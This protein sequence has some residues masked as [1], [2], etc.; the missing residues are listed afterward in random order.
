[1]KPAVSSAAVTVCAGC[2]T[3]L[4]V[5]VMLSPATMPEGTLTLMPTVA[6][7]PSSVLEITPS[8]LPSVVISTT[9][10]PEAAATTALS[11]PAGLVPLVLVAVA[12][13]V[14]VLPAGGVGAVTVKWPAAR[15][16]AVTMCSGCA[17]PLM[18]TAMVSP[19][20]RPAGTPIFTLRLAAPPISA[21]V[22]MPSPGFPSATISTVGLGTA[23]VGGVGGT[24]GVGGVGGVGGGSVGGGGNGG[25]GG[26]GGCGGGGDGGDGGVGAS[27]PPP[28]PPPPPP[29]AKASKPAPAITGS[30]SA[31]AA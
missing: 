22:R 7:P 19:A 25:C 13:T 18:V 10:A 5:T 17:T 9:G 31:D 27:L 21:L 6:E 1:M 29:P 28:P 14:K 3:P 20:M 15:S 24:G 12:V 11:L 4:T 23:G 30:M 2:A 16:A 8:L 26:C